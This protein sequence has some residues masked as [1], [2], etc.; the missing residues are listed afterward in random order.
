LQGALLH[1]LRVVAALINQ[2]DHSMSYQL[3]TSAIDDLEYLLNYRFNGEPPKK[4]PVPPAC[5][6]YASPIFW[7]LDDDGDAK[8]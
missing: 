8:P 1:K 3:L 5:G 7:K 4:G 6:C 2:H